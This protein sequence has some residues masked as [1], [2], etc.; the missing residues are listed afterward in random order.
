MIAQW[1]YTQWQ[2][3][4]V[5]IHYISGLYAGAQYKSLSQCVNALNDKSRFKSLCW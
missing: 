4:V 1:W 2:E 3:Y 5:M